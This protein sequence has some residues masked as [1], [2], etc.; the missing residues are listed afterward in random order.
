MGCRPSVGGGA[1]PR[2][3]PP[4]ARSTRRPARDGSGSGRRP[5]RRDHDHRRRALRAGSADDH[6]AIASSGPTPPAATAVAT[7]ASRQ[8]REE[9]Q[10]ERRPVAASASARATRKAA[11]PHTASRS[12]G[13]TSRQRPASDRSFDERRRSGSGRS[14]HAAASISRK[15]AAVSPK[16]AARQE[17]RPWQRPGRAPP[18][19]PRAPAASRSRHSATSG[20][21][22]HTPTAAPTA[23]RPRAGSDASGAASV[24]AATQQREPRRV[25]PVGLRIEA[26]DREAEVGLVLV[27]DR[28]REGRDPARRH[29]E[30]EQQP[31]GDAQPAVRQA[32]EVPGAQRARRSTHRRRPAGS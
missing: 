6:R 12:W 25:R 3:R 10:R 7:P 16:A 21:R 28:G 26:G 2:A 23:C 19:P 31:E 17:P 11:M 22:V 13:R 8:H 9:R 1:R 32:E 14:H 24:P 30:Q 4:P 15:V 18:P 29:R 20:Y 27:P 5:T